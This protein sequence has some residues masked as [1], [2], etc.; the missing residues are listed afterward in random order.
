MP[1]YILHM[2]ITAPPATSQVSNNFYGILESY[3]I[4][5]GLISKVYSLGHVLE[6]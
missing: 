2:A 1:Q 6:Q 5:I 4:A 3:K